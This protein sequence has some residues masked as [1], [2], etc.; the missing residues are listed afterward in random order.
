M[1]RGSES[2]RNKST[3]VVKHFYMETMLGESLYIALLSSS[4]KLKIRVEQV[5][6][7]SEGSWGPEGGCGRAGGRNNSN[8]VCTCE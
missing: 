4:T 1:T 8:I 2:V 7:G 6:P 5:L 3:W